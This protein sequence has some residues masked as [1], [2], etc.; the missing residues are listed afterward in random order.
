M[1]VELPP[2]LSNRDGFCLPASKLG[3][4]CERAW[5]GACD[6]A[7]G[8]LSDPGEQVAGNGVGDVMK[9]IVPKMH[10]GGQF[11]TPAIQSMHLPS[12]VAARLESSP[13]Q[14]AGVSQGNLETHSSQLGAYSGRMEVIQTRPNVSRAQRKVLQASHI[15]R[16]AHP[17]LQGTTYTADLGEVVP[18][19]LEASPDHQTAPGLGFGFYFPEMGGDLTKTGSRYRVGLANLGNTCFMNSVLQALASSQPLMSYCTNGMFIRDL[20]SASPDTLGGRSLAELREHHER[21]SQWAIGADHSITSEIQAR[22][23]SLIE[24]CFDCDQYGDSTM[25]FLQ[26]YR[27]H[28]LT[29]HAHMPTGWS[30]LA[31]CVLAVKWAVML[32]EK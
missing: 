15:P 14:E 16:T 28:A 23:R 18:G 2:N 13:L 21:H 27:A 30:A 8:V 12:M 32:G 10:T 19:R 24:F 25:E 5:R 1:S 9:A 20:R 11:V 29:E 17:A 26:F 7:V 31:A 22:F 4:V 6:F 3:G